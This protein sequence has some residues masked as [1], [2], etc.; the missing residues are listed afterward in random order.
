[1][2]SEKRVTNM[3]VKPCLNLVLS[4]YS[5]LSFF[6]TIS[7]GRFSVPREPCSCREIAHKGVWMNV[8]TLD[9]E[10]DRTKGI[11]I[12]GLPCMSLS[13]AVWVNSGEM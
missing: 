4:V 5:L 13:L 11:I 6:C 1:M 12:L 3:F 2:N 10:A 8:Q 7:H 9:Q